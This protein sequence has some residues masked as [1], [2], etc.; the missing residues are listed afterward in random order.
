MASLFGRK[1]SESGSDKQ[2][3]I[4]QHLNKEISLNIKKLQRDHISSASAIRSGETVNRICSCLEAIFLHE[5]KDSY[6]S[7]TFWPFITKFTHRDVLEQI[8]QLLF[9]RT[10]IGQCRAWIR[11][12]VNDCLM[13]SYFS[14]ILREPSTL[15]QYYK[16]GAFLRDSEL[17]LI[18]NNYLQG[19]SVFTF[20]L[21]CNSSVLNMWDTA[22][23]L[24]SGAYLSNPENHESTGPDK[25]TEDSS[26]SGAD[27]KWDSARTSSFHEADIS[28]SLLK[29][30]DNLSESSYQ[31]GEK[32]SNGENVVDRQVA[33]DTPVQ[34]EEFEDSIVI[35]L[36]SPD[37]AEKGIRSE[38]K[39]VSDIPGEHSEKRLAF[40]ANVDEISA[41][42][43]NQEKEEEDSLDE[44]NP[45][46]SGHLDRDDDPLVF[47][48]TSDKKDKKKKAKNGRRVATD[49]KEESMTKT[50]EEEPT[51][52][53]DISG[54][55][56][57]KTFTPSADIGHVPDG[58]RK[59]EELL[60][61]SN[62]FSSGLSRQDDDRLVTSRTTDEKGTKKKKNKAKS[63]AARL[64]DDSV[65][66][67][68]HEREKK[69][70]ESTEREMSRTEA[71]GDVEGEMERSETR[72]KSGR[73][74]DIY[75]FESRSSLRKQK[76]RESR[77]EWVEKK[78]TDGG[79]VVVPTI[80][81]ENKGIDVEIRIDDRRDP[82]QRHGADV[83]EESG[84]GIRD[85]QS[86]ESFGNSLTGMQGWSSDFNRTASPGPQSTVVTESQ[87][88]Y[89]TM[90]GNYIDN[91]AQG[92][93]RLESSRRSEGQQTATED[94]GTG[95]QRTQALLD[96][97]S[98]IGREKGLAAQKFQC[99]G[100]SCELGIIFGKHK[101]CN[102]DGYYYCSECH[103]D[104]QAV[105]PARILYNWDF[106]K[107]CVARH[108]KL[109]LNQVE[110][111]ALIDVGKYN[112]SLYGAISE[113]EQ[114]L[115][116][117]KQILYLKA[118]LFTCKQSVAEQ[119][120]TKIWPREYMLENC[121]L[122]SVRD[123]LQVQSGNLG[124]QL[125]KIIVFAARHVQQCAL[126]SQ[127]GFICEIC[128]NPKIIYPFDTDLTVR[129]DKCRSVFHRSC[130]TDIQPC[131]RCLRRKLR[132]PMDEEKD[133]RTQFPSP[134]T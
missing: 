1:G 85:E 67:E 30:D 14:S 13:D 70:S 101:V 56:S 39:M 45:F 12:A 77:E 62:P 25:S 88:S 8:K 34:V 20:Q 111:M 109:F 43:K 21:S 107:H 120:R 29:E 124:P 61:E 9:I 87:E 2:Q 69:E 126:C 11:M 41:G 48:R 26:V 114:I 110:D 119:L 60:D 19:L 106:R 125:K 57:E 24:L 6:T 47:S 116:L 37:K 129:C 115:A 27:P 131:P 97:V 5:L 16:Q 92:I 100:C 17:P 42:M 3:T 89:S 74:E 75:R 65:G 55:V 51:P 90:V 80:A 117:R 94:Q 132:S 103:L 123:L 33:E 28:A 64:R 23:L 122:Y 73:E 72:D 118:Y 58:R 71:V 96:M 59:E 105:I 127:K 91:S 66:D 93:Q 54:E 22:L 108:T 53:G 10:E 113:M 83:Q 44:S 133:D 50:S 99:R 32:R 104:E 76:N 98:Q 18:T 134:F 31:R 52:A 81:E 36:E 78:L 38:D 130:K 86:S 7:K 102:Y 35:H 63:S 121:H 128:E 46:S 95:E 49:I 68:V 15:K 82:T 4:K 112:P 84:K 79:R 40:R